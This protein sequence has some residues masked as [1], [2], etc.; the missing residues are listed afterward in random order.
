[1]C[2][3]FLFN[4][5]L[6]LAMKKYKKSI[7]NISVSKDRYVLLFNA[8]SGSAIVL[9]DEAYDQFNSFSFD[10]NTVIAYL[11]RGFLVDSECDEF[12]RIQQESENTPYKKKIHKYRILTTSACNA[13]CFYCYEKGLR[14]YTMT[15]SV[16]L[17][18]A[19][20]IVKHVNE[21]DRIR[22]EWFG[23]EPLMNMPAIDTIMKYLTEHLSPYLDF[24]TTIVTNGSR[25]NEEVIEKMVYHWR[26]KRIQITI[27]GVGEKYEEVKGLGRG[28][29]RRII[30]TIGK[31]VEAKINVDI[32]LNYDA[33]NLEDIKEV[34]RF[35]SSYQYKDRI[36]IYAAK[37]FS[38][39]TRRGYFDLEKETLEVEELLYTLGLKKGLA[40]LPR[41]FTTGCMATYP[42]FYTIDPDGKL[43]KC[44]RKLLDGN[45]VATVSKYDEDALYRHRWNNLEV[46]SKCEICALYPMCWG[47]CIYDPC[48]LTNSIV[49]HNLMLLLNDYLKR[50]QTV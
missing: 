28:S 9:T 15:P 45:I 7:Y 32:R 1:M 34:I 27:D 37:I 21:G 23:G 8:A 22:I 50:R 3:P 39:I 10:E 25:I 40:L 41:T 49:E 6:M 26:I 29:F 19:K 20:F 14:R 2:P 33:S 13:K 5:Y 4:L 18:T 35:F 12:T 17:D 48:Y 30:S 44:D 31:L 47:G 36:T 38:E 24:H 11:D 16:A 46:E 42:G 43:F